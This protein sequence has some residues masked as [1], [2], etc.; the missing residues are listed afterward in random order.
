MIETQ[1]MTQRNAEILEQLKL[2]I[3]AAVIARKYDLSRARVNQLSHR[4]GI[5]KWS[6]KMDRQP[7]KS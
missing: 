2:G 4:Y 5:Y 6:K 1:Q 7:E 3:P